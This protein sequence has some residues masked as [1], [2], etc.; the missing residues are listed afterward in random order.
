MM[1]INSS[2][3]ITAHPD[4]YIGSDQ[5]TGRNRGIIDPAVVP[6]SGD[7]D[8]ATAISQRIQNGDPGPGQNA[9]DANNP[10]E[11]G[12]RETDR[13]PVYNIE[14]AGGRTL[15]EAEVK[16]LEQLKISDRE[17]RAHEMAHVIAGGQFVRRGASF[18]YRRGP[19]GKRYAVA[20]EVRIDAS[21]V[22]GDP[23]ATA[24]K[25]ERIKRAA[26]APAN[27]SGQDR[28]IAARAAMI[29]ADALMDLTLMR[30]KERSSLSQAVAQG[31][32]GAV[33]DVYS[34]AGGIDETGRT[35]DLIG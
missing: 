28:H 22:P 30:V 26:L 12:N 32:N 35:I 13:A 10:G 34:Q 25:M 9:A 1:Q 29:R 15:S 11:N 8:A 24:E 20:G 2:S 19:D 5:P 33:P 4:R 31:V 7:S 3:S 6:R 16:L 21:E 14:T 18:E 17:V 23:A 27:P